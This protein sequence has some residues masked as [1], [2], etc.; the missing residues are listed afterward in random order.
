MTMGTRIN[1]TEDQAADRIRGEGF[2]RVFRVGT[3]YSGR[4]FDREILAEDPRVAL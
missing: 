2:D 3:R 4:T 1:W